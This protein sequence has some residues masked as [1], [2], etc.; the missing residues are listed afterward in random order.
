MENTNS[1]INNEQDPKVKTEVTLQSL[2]ESGAHFGT[3]KA[4][5]NPA[6]SPYIFCVRN[7]VYIINLQ[8]TLKLWKSA[9]QSIVD[10]VSKGGKVL[11]VA[12]KKQTREVLVAEAKKAGVFYIENKWLGGTLTN[13]PVLRKSVTQLEKLEK[14]VADAEKPNSSIEINK[15]ELTKLKKEIE[16]K[17]KAFGGIRGMKK[18]PD[19]IFLVDVS[20]DKLCLEEA[21][22]L[23]IPVVALADTNTDPQN[24]TH[25]IPA[26]DDANATQFLFIRAVTLA[27]LEGKQLFEASKVEKAKPVEPIVENTQEPVEASI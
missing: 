7:G 24:I 5:W 17:E 6:M 20:K 9:R 10:V 12:T 25:I 22:K 27:V 2:L 13:L 15:K 18:I 14:L 23:Q 26:N 1:N 8:T 16:K 19:L 21:I 11:F 3:R 4:M